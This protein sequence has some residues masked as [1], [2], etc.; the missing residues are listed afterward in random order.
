MQR[1]GAVAALKP[2]NDN[3]DND[4]I[5]IVTERFERRLSEETGRLRVEIA[6]LRTEMVT[7]FAE[8][9]ADTA[10]LRTEMVAGFGESRTQIAQLR[11]EM[12]DR[13]ANLLK[14]GLAFGVT[15]TAAIAGIVALLR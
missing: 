1:R 15:Q 11:A 13:N 8:G 9:R 5:V 7:G 2:M 12:I 3:N 10:K 14:W 6:D 4:D